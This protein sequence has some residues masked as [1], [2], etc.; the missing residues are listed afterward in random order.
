MEYKRSTG[1]IAAL[2]LGAVVTALLVVS[3]GG[4]QAF[5]LE[6]G[7]PSRIST[8]KYEYIN[9]SESSAARTNNQIDNAKIS[10]IKPSF[11]I[12][13]GESAVTLHGGS[14]FQDNGEA[15]N[16]FVKEHPNIVQAVKD[17]GDLSDIDSSN[18]TQYAEATSE[19]GNYPGEFMASF[20]DTYAVR[21][22]NQEL[23]YLTA[24]YNT[25]KDASSLAVLY[26]AAPRTQDN[27]QALSDLESRPEVKKILWKDKAGYNI[28]GAVSYARQWAWSPNPAYRNFDS[29]GGN[30]TNFASQILLAG[31]DG[32]NSAWYYN[33]SGQSLTWINANAFSNYVGKKY[34]TSDFL[35]FSSTLKTGDF[36]GFDRN[37]DGI[38]DH[39]GFVSDRTGELITRRGKRFYNFAVAQHSA[40]YNSWVGT[41]NNNWQ[42]GDGKY[43][44]YRLH[45]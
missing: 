32:M 11:Q 16:N 22:F 31:G 8:E 2:P 1:K 44:F 7:F 12:R 29:V 43:T 37:N 40:F 42:S 28:P 26:F 3:A 5:S 13:L 25:S 14:E 38:L 15:L 41:G 10:L 30:C 24:K 34:Q 6:S 27:I 19:M 20:L 21:Y 4:I 18:W 35:S 23:R 45:T 9:E 39:I 36:I 33:N 17:F